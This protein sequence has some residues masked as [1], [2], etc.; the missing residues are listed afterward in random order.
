MNQ[1]TSQSVWKKGIIATVLFI[2][3]LLPSAAFAALEVQFQATPLFV[4][5]DVK[6]GDVVSRTVIVT[7]TGPE[8]ETIIFDFRN[9]FSDGLADVMELAVTTDSNT[10]ADNFF[11]NLFALG[12]INLGELAA[13]ASQE[14][15]F[16]ASLDPATGNEY[17]LSEFGFDLLIGF[18]GGE[19]VTDGGGGNGGGGGGGG[20]NNGGSSEFNLFN[21]AVTTPTNSSADLTWNTN[22]PATSFAVC[23][24]LEN[25]PFTLDANDELFG[26]EF[27]STEDVT[28]SLEH[29]MSFTR[30]EIGEYECRVASREQVSDRF[31]VSGPLRFAFLP[32]GQVE[33]VTTSVTPRPIINSNF[34]TPTGLVAGASDNGG[35]GTLGGPTYAEWRAE[36]DERRANEIA[37]EAA[38]DAA[39]QAERDE[40]ALRARESVTASS[41]DQT[42]EPDSVVGFVTNN[43]WWLLLLGL[44]AVISA[45]TLAKMRR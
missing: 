13:G 15:V 8:A 26:Y 27:S 34:F 12:E 7:N 31:T 10:F 9:E 44:L 1:L 11:T 22:R 2:F 30:L 24:N 39:V 37:A 32:P 35:K 14:Y 4:D 43:W 28:K 17:Q 23:G 40:R 3:G 5:A 38:A 45:R 33:G 16:T 18:Q 36:L 20:G 21:E 42:S 41:G 19:T 25:G 29:E 6:P